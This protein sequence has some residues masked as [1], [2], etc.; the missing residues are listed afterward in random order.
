MTVINCDAWLIVVIGAKY[1]LKMVPQ[2]SHDHKKFIC[3][4]E[5]IGCVDGADLFKKPV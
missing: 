1:V 3:H 5:M 2:G 4:S